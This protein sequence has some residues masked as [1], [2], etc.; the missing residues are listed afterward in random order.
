[1]I[2]FTI[3]TLVVRFVFSCFRLIVCNKYKWKKLFHT[4]LTRILLVNCM[5]SHTII[6][7]F[8]RLVFSSW[9][10]PVWNKYVQKQQSA[11][12][13]N[14]MV[15]RKF[16]L[17]EFT[18]HF[19][20]ISLLRVPFF[21][22]VSLKQIHTKTTVC[23]VLEQNGVLKVS[24]AWVH[25]PFLLYFSA[26]CSL[27]HGCQPETNTYKINCLLLLWLW[28]CYKT[29]GSTYLF[30]LT[31]FS[32]MICSWLHTTIS[33][34]QMCVCEQLKEFYWYPSQSGGHRAKGWT[35]HVVYWKRLITWWH[36]AR[37][38]CNEPS[39]CTEL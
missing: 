35:V 14:R 33:L 2:L 12:F 18:Y 26:S 32:G 3:C 16:Q 20:F 30:P 10:L 11:T 22:A 5:I 37:L 9:R 6:T 1:M 4:F 25:I 17:R 28:Q 29:Y 34:K 31:S 21:K 38:H 36:W 27:L 23:Y 7:L 8:L 39:V 24:I 13:L 15:F 19:Y